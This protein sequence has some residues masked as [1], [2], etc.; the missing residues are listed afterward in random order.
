[1][2]SPNPIKSEVTLIPEHIRSNL[3][4]FSDHK[5]HTCLE[6]GYVG[7]MGKLEISKSLIYK[8]F[9]YGGGLCIFFLSVLYEYTPPSWLCVLFGAFLYWL[10]APNNVFVCPNCEYPIKQTTNEHPEVD[11]NLHQQEHTDAIQNKNKNKFETSALK[12]DEIQKSSEQAIQ[13]KNTTKKD[14]LIGFIFFGLICYLVW[15][16]VVAPLGRLAF[17]SNGE[18]LYQRYLAAGNNVAEFKE[19]FI[20]GEILSEIK[21]DNG[22]CYFGWIE[23]KWVSIDGEA[24]P[25]NKTNVLY[26]FTYEQDAQYLTSFRGESY[27]DDLN[28]AWD[29]HQCGDFPKKRK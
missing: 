23:L 25:S 27:I 24:V 13:S 26:I 11:S 28:S 20:D 18:F 21:T 22:K 15:H 3:N 7:L 17:G 8:F 14:T 19:K 6:C 1:M 2:N 5:E 9:I 4:K 12:A 16:F 10:A 29:Q